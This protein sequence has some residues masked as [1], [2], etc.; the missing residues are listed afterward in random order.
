MHRTLGTSSAAGD[1]TTARLR[2]VLLVF[3]YLVAP[4]VFAVMFSDRIGPRLAIAWIVGI[5]VSALGLMFSYDRPSGPTIMCIF[6]VV[7]MAGGV[8]K[9]LR[10][11]LGTLTALGGTLALFVAMSFGGR[12]ALH[13]LAAPIHG[14]QHSVDSAHDEDLKSP[15]GT[16]EHGFGES[17]RDLQTAMS[18]EHANVRAEAALKLGES[19]SSGALPFLLKALSDSSDAVKENAAR[20]LAMLGDP[21]AIPHLRR[22]L[23]VT[24]GDPWVKFRMIQALAM[25]GDKRAIPAL[26]ETTA[27]DGPGLLRNEALRSL[28]ALRGT[29]GSVSI[30]ISSP[31]GKALVREMNSWW[32]ERG[33][34]LEFDRASR[35]FISPRGKDH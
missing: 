22:L 27:D 29:S 15:H 23:K 13:Q 10:D 17:L 7:L 34:Q 16:S 12:F 14:T 1:L 2:R 6:A 4:A 25:S 28:E 5:L 20:S 33:A 9:F 24:Q 30:D 3:C 8:F 11:R 19:R 31:E 21:A 26:L 35:T 32:K 18:D